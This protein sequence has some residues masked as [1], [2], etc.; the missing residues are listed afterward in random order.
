MSTV[1]IN[2]H[3]IR[4]YDRKSKPQ[5]TIAF[6]D[7]EDV[8]TGDKVVHVGIAQCSR[9]D[10]FNKS[11]GRLLA[12][13]RALKAKENFQYGKPTKVYANKSYIPVVNIRTDCETKRDIINEITAMFRLNSCG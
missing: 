2:F 8:K 1:K 13:G 10:Q 4:N 3:H 11:K 12:E 9:K 7:G 5:Y 6:V